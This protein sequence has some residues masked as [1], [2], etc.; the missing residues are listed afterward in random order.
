[1]A[2]QRETGGKEKKEDVTKEKKTRQGV[3]FGKTGVRS[4]KHKTEKKRWSMPSG[5]GGLS[6]RD[7]GLYILKRKAEGGSFDQ[8]W[9]PSERK[10]E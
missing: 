7:G 5:E 4:K 2:G 1:V 6:S 10:E 8:W 3:R 9:G